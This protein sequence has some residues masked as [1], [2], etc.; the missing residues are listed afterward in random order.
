MAAKL[1][2]PE[3]EHLFLQVG[4]RIEQSAEH[5]E[6]NQLWMEGWVHWFLK[7]LGRQLYTPYY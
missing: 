3:N 1:S 5:Q 6:V 4:L 2:I 7:L